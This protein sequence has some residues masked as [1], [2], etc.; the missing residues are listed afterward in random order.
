MKKHFTQSGLLLLIII[1]AA[2]CLFTFA[3]IILVSAKQ[4]DKQSNIIAER[5]TEYYTACNKAHEYIADSLDINDTYEQT[6]IINEEEN[7]YIKYEVNNHTYKI[8]NW[9]VINIA[10][11]NPDNSLN[12][13]K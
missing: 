3:S 4:T 12:L 9:Q 1:F 7:L 13:I 6:F 10:D 8:I 5:Q 11:W 2:T